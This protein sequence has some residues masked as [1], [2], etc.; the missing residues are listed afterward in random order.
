MK[1]KKTTKTAEIP[2]AVA[3]GKTKPAT[4]SDAKVNAKEPKTPVAIKPSINKGVSTNMR[5][6][7]YQDH[8]LSIQPK[9]KLSDEDL[10]ADWRTEFPNAK[11]RFDATIVAGV[12]RL[13]NAGKH[14]SQQVQ[15]PANGVSRYEDGKPVAEKKRESRKESKAA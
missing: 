12:R 6:M 4:T 1:L 14:G 7:Q 2:A 9:R 8:T 10:A 11:G 3:K 13:F 15:P 5:V